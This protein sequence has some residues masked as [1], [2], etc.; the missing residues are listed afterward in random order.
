MSRDS[1]RR[2]KITRLLPVL[3][4]GGV[5]SRV[6]LQSQMIDRA[7]FDYRVCAFWKCGEAGRRIRRAGI[8]VDVLGVD[9]T[10]RNPMATAKLTSYLRDDPPHILHSSIAEANLHGTL[11]AAMAGVPCRII[12]EVGIPSRGR[13]GRLAFGGIYNLAHRIVGVSRAT[14]DVLR[15]EGAPEDKLR[16]IYNC[17]NPTFFNGPMIERPSTP[18]VQFLAVGRLVPVKNHAN[19]LR[20]FR[21]VVS[22]LPRVRLRIAGEGPLRD[23]LS[24]L[25]QQLGL[26]EHVELLGFRSD[27][28]DLLQR[29]HIFLLPSHQE[30]CSISLVE[31]MSS[32]IVPLG[33][34]AEGIT[35]VMGSLEGYQ[36]PPDDIGAWA[37]SM[38]GVASMTPPDRH[39]IGR[40]ARQIAKRRFSPGV[41]NRNVLRMYREMA[42]SAG[43]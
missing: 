14:C 40:R 8:P 17:A 22:A 20:A 29:S 25:I 16:L 3:D 2:I 18:P 9:P 19:L 5:E 33:S 42:A 15:L 13:L 12:E 23:H 36:I 10:V 41:Y 30:G 43:L 21:Q 31:A 4:F 35:E 24:A 6:V 11:A 34:T 37:E 39:R 7:E 26:G 32:G 38:I 1:S 27:V 28:L